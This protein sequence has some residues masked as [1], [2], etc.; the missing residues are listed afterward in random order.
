M[1]RRKRCTR[2]G[3][4]GF[5]PPESGSAPPEPVARR[6]NV[7]A[8]LLSLRA[9]GGRG[10]VLEIRHAI[11]GVLERIRFHSEADA[12]HWFETIRDDVDVANL[13]TVKRSRKTDDT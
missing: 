3:G 11:R 10:W 9:L 4:T 8:L 12:H 7:G 13:M 2:C 6:R 5:E 1:S